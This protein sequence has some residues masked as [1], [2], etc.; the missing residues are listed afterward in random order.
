MA[1]VAP[2]GWPQAMS[3]RAQR[4]VARV[5]RALPLGLSRAFYAE[6]R[7]DGA[8]DQADV[9]IA[10]ARDARDSW[11]TWLR[12]A[13]AQATLA[14]RH[15]A[16]PTI[17]SLLDDWA[18]DHALDRD[19]A[20]LW[21][22]FD[23]PPARGGHVAA[24][25]PSCFVGLASHAS[26]SP[27]SLLAMA[28]RLDPSMS[29]ATSA[30]RRATCARAPAC[31]RERALARVLGA[32][33]AGISVGQL[34]FLLGRDVSTPIR[35][36]LSGIQPG[37]LDDTL[38]ALGVP[39]V[40]LQA[41]LHTLLREPGAP[42]L[43]YVD[44]DV[45]A[46]VLPRVGVELRCDRRTQALGRL[47]EATWLQRLVSAGLASA[48]W[49]DALADWP[50]GR[51]V[52]M[53]HQL[54]PSVAVRRLNHVKLTWQDGAF[55]QAKGYCLLRFDDAPS[56]RHGPV[57]SASSDPVRSPRHHSTIRSPDVLATFPT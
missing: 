38:A 7:L 21:L 44:I 24:S 16:W 32:L 41:A 54:W 56:R 15:R 53:P 17:A 1:H 31:S 19:I 55:H 43:D 6:V 45:A 46:D 49:A 52:V 14:P 4:D 35:L 50:A 8:D 51:R 5:A 29:A 48:G 22:E 13:P 2:G 9:S 36:C 34:G 10:V 28:T 30:A 12:D 3:A 33:P 27:D 47:H 25:A 11:R 37:A 18:A 42:Q 20:H 57:P 26:Q 23:R 39:A 40:R